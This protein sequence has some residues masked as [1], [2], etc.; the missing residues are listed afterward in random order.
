MTSEAGCRIGVPHTSAKIAQ[1]SNNLGF[2]EESIPPFYPPSCAL[3]PWALP[4]H[5]EPCMRGAAVPRSVGWPG[6][7]NPT[8]GQPDPQMQANDSL[9]AI[10]RA[11]ILR[12]GES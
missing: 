1:H 12:V 3:L 10:G 9:I 11:R 4:E 7:M 5:S 6:R 2:S 8:P